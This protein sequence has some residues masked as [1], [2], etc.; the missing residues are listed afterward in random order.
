M[1]ENLPSWALWAGFF[2]SLSIL[3]GVAYWAL[4]SATLFMVKKLQDDGEIPQMDKLKVMETNLSSEIKA[5]DAKIENGIRS[6]LGRQSA[7]Q[8]ETGADIKKIAASVNTMSGQLEEHLR[9]DG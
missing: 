4:Y 7:W 5:V 1:F 8:I 3:A 6:E 2:V 9:Q